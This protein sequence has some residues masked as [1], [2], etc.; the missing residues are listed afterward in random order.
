MK[1]SQL[2][3][4]AHL[5]GGESILHAGDCAVSMGMSAVQFFLVTPFRLELV[6]VDSLVAARYRDKYGHLTTVVHGPFVLNLTTEKL[7]DKFC[8]KYLLSLVTGAILVGAKYIV[9]HIGS[10][11]IP[12]EGRRILKRRMRKLLP[13][14]KKCGVVICLETDV[15][16]GDRIGSYKNLRNV[17][18]S[19]KSPWLK[20]C[21]DT[22]HM[23]AAGI[24]LTKAKVLE[25][26]KKEKELVAVVHINEPEPKVKFN[27]HLDRHNN[28]FGTGPI[29]EKILL[30]FGQA[31]RDKV[32]I[33]ECRD[34]EAVAFNVKMLREGLNGSC[35]M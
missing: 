22:A 26:I 7:C 4:G 3:L 29:G 14:L 17:V 10:N 13:T 15:G 20:L 11:P 33:V 18:K 6:V 30:R 23:Y 1:E 16:G 32:M 28:K 9:L 8:V 19:I 35:V 25:K 34:K 12:Q 2:K 21:L 5:G 31:F 27:G 24:D